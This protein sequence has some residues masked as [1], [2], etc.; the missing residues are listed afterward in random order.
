M[1][2]EMSDEHPDRVEQFFEGK[3]VLISGAT[4]FLGKVLIEKLLR[5][6]PKVEY[7]VPLVRIKK[8]KSPEQRMQ[9]IFEGPVSRL[10][11]SFRD[12]I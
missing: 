9:E 1:P 8:N 7:V 2:T 4:G 11:V 5:A 6:C 10:L 3:T 12:A